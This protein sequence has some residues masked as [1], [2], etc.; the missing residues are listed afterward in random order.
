MATTLQAY[1]FTEADH[2][3]IDQ[4]VLSM[5]CLCSTCFSSWV[6]DH[7][8]NEAEHVLV[9][10]R[11]YLPFETE[12]LSLNLLSGQIPFAALYLPRGYGRPSSTR[13]LYDLVVYED[14]TELLADLLDY[15]A[16]LELGKIVETMPSELIAL[17]AQSAAE[18]G[19]NLMRIPLDAICVPPR[20][21]SLLQEEAFRRRFW[22]VVERRMPAVRHIVTATATQH[23]QVANRF[24]QERL[25]SAPRSTGLGILETLLNAVGIA[26]ISS[27]GEYLRDDD[28]FDM[29]GLLRAMRDR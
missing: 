17:F 8:V 12:A 10:A 15:P 27:L 26:D 11:A 19:G 18:F 25:A 21:V 14:N 6:P 29:I 20:Y 5:H 16:I 2:L 24:L 28:G 1:G 13:V 7:E 3:E 9:H 23:L 4:N 22:Q